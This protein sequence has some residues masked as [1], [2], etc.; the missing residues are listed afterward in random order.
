M[1]PLKFEK[2]MEV[3]RQQSDRSEFVASAYVASAIGNKR[4]V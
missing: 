1:K 3:E 2:V 4:G